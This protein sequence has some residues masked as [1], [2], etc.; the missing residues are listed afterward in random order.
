MITKLK[1]FLVQSV[2]V[3]HLLRK[4]TMDEYKSISKVSALG[5]ILIGALGFVVGDLIQLIGKIFSG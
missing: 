2:R 1:S 4:P 3:W 5:I